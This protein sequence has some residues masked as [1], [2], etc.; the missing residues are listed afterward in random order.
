MTCQCITNYERQQDSSA[1]VSVVQS[2]SLVTK[3]DITNYGYNEAHKLVPTKILLY[4]NRNASVIANSGYK[5]IS[6]IANWFCYPQRTIMPLV[7]NR[8][9]VTNHMFGP[10][11]KFKLVSLC[12]AS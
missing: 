8:P 1:P 9:L 4:M 10:C 12:S 3:S 6:V 7:T 5:E 2:R 11:E